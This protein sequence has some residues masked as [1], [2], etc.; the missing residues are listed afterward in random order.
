LS[1]SFSGRAALR[2]VDLSVE[3]GEVHGLLG[4]NGSGK[5]TLIKILSGYHRPDPGASLTVR[6][7]EIELPVAPGEARKLGMSFVHQDLGL[8]PAMT[9]LENFRVGAF[10][11]HF[12]WRVN[13]REE[14]RIVRQA[15]DTFGMSCDPEALVSSLGEVER[16][17]V[18]IVRALEE[19]RR[20]EAGLLVL[21]EPTPYLPRDGVDRL[22]ERV[23]AAAA[24]GIGVLFVSHRLEEVQALTDR[25]S[26]LRDG[27]LVGTVATAS[28]TERDLIELILGFT[29]D[30]LYPTPQEAEGEL[31]FRIY[32]ASSEAVESFTL[33]VRCGEIVGVTGLLGMGWERI[34]YLVFG[35]EESGAGTLEAN[36]GTFDLRRFTPG[37]AI[38]EGFALLP[39]NRARDGGLLDATVA[40]NLTLPTVGAYFAHGVLHH[41]REAQRVASLLREF[42][43][44]PPEGDRSLATLSGGNQQKVLVAKWLETHPKVLLLH[45]PTQ[46]VDVGARAQI[47][48]RI[49]DAAAKG[50]AVVIAS[51]EYEDLVHLCDRVIVFRDG[52]AV[53]NISG[54]ALTIDRLVEQSLR[55]G[56]PARATQGAG[57]AGGP[58]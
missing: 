34:P 27:R 49:A 43:V 6:G 17:M 46:G 14:R 10:R 29:L 21:D 38:R 55:A 11:S 30:E 9:V 51:S 24:A 5:S 12:G 50:T 44:R 32:D 13:W 31:A 19:L 47:F 18:A 28:V 33:D 56:G 1:K 48:A 53:S 45:E 37:R 57:A 22:F 25:V 20:T 2:S 3:A 35:A 41:R 39:A 23:R 8:S 54:A 40:E 15:L 52:R 7:H 26:V 36:G 16:A 58:T 42:D 4:Q